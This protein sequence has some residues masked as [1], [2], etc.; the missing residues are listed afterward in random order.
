MQEINSFPLAGRPARW[1]SGQQ[2][3]TRLLLSLAALAATALSPAQAQIRP[4][5]PQVPVAVGAG[6]YAS[7]PPTDND[8]TR[9]DF[10]YRD[11]IYVAANK[12]NGPMP[13][14]DWWT[15]L[16]VRGKNA[17]L[18]WATPLVVDPEPDGVKFNFPNSFNAGGGDMLYGG[19]MHITADGYTPS[20]VVAADWSDWGLVV[21]MPDTVSGK[22]LKVTMAHGVPFAWVE[23]QGLNPAFAFEKD[24]TFLTAAGAPLTLPA[25]S[26]FVVNTD[27]RYLGIHLGPNST[28]QIEGQQFVSIDLGAV[29]NLSDVKLYWENAYGSGYAVQVSNDNLNWATVFTETNGDGGLDDIPNLTASARYVRLLLN[30]RGSNFA[31]SLYEFQVFDGATLLSQNQPVTVSSTQTTGN[32]IAAQLNDGNFGTRWASDV[33][34]QPRLVMTTPASSYFVV[35]ALNAPADLTAYEAYAFN[36]VTNTNVA[37]TYNATTGK[38]NLNWT[39]TTTNLQG[40]AAGNTLQG[41]LPHLYANTTNSIAFL[42][43]EYASSHGRLKMATGSAFA[44]TYDFAGILPSYTAPYRNAADAHPYDAKAMYDLVTAFAGRTDYNTETYYGGKDI[45]NF[46]KYALIAKELNHQA[47]PV[48]KARARAALVNWLTY[49][50]GETSKYFARY[51][52]WGAYIGFDPDFGSDQFTDNHFHYG[53]FTLAC[54]LYSMLDQTFLPQY[55]DMAKLIAKEY[56]NWDRTDTRVPYFRTFDP[57]IGHSYAGGTSS[58]SGNNQ[59]SSSES[60]QS[61]MGLFLLGDALNDPAM[62]DAGAFGYT[63]EAAATLEYWFDWKQRN[64]QPNFPYNMAAIVSNQGVG[65]VTFFGDFPHYVH[66]IEYLPVNPGLSYLARDTAWARREYNDLLAEGRAYPNQNFATDLDY[67]DDWTHVVWGF[68]QLFDPNYVTGQMEANYRLAAS[69]PHYVMDDR[70]VAGLTYFYAHANQNLGFFSSKFHT[71]FPTSSVFER[72][73]AFSHAVAY[74]PT[75]TPRTATVYD[76]QGNTVASAL[77]PAYTLLTFPALPTTGSTPTGC[78]RLLATQAKASSGANSAAAAVDGDQGSRWESAFSDP[79]QITVDYG[80]AATMAYVRISWENASAKDY[81]LLASVD[82]VTWTTLATKTNLPTLPNG[83]HRVDTIAV[84]GGPYRYLRMAGTTR[85]TPYGYSIYEMTPCGTALTATVSPLP[86]QLID[87]TAQPEGAAVALAWH[88]ASEKNSARFEIERS[89]DGKRF[90]HLGNVAAQ[91]SASK[92]TAYAYRDDALPAG[93][94]QLYYRLRQVDLDGSAA[95]SP[96][97]TVALARTTSLALFPNPAHT[98]ATLTGAAPGTTVQLYDAVGRR[99]TA[100]TADAAGT[101]TYTLPVGL[102][103]GVYVVHAGGKALRL[104]VQ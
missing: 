82:S 25:T 96:V 93:I 36:K 77:I 5:V 68:R 20:T 72:N 38:V 41:F 80:S 100:A 85:T 46:V 78:Y 24:A 44:F 50:P 55:G 92:L 74:N 61:W 104:L 70:E 32:F 73:G 22:S 64:L 19:N 1:D 42:N 48:L 67:G 29:H 47:A 58:G 9:Y 13:T 53:Y 4:P 31:Y 10:V 63:S 65:H 21:N 89:T 16:L 102:P 39:L 52:R 94:S 34:Q 14:N 84:T 17:G 76:A 49:T 79:Q 86:V 62:R 23:T 12:K 56:A 54:A 3:F 2:G 75:A 69:D 99:V 59:E 98:A 26:S 57:W 51:D 40:Q 87:F 27:G 45:L 88:T 71:D 37:Y 35:S 90:A 91:G 15:D 103:G 101:A 83:Q 43:Y 60:M 28:V 81:T 30:K 18:L 7:A 95:Y 66:G 33:N 97:R 11:P 6:S 8:A